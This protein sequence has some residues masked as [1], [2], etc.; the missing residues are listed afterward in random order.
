MTPIYDGIIE[1]AK[2]KGD[3]ES[4][5]LAHTVWNGT[6]WVIDVWL[7]DVDDIGEYGDERRI[8]EWCNHNV[9]KEAWPIHGKPGQWYRA[10]FSVNGWTWIGF[11]TEENMR[12]FMQSWPQNIKPAEAA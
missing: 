12:L 4:L 5:E 10:G 8:R 1:H 11:D 6:P 2:N 9:G 7:G 3:K